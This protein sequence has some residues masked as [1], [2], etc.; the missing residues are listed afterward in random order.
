MSSEDLKRKL[1][2][3]PNEAGSYQMLNRDGHIIYVGKAKNIKKRVNS[4]FTHAIS[5]KTK[6]L[7]N[8]IYD[9]K[10]IVT[11]TELEALILEINL[12]KKYNPKYNI[13]LKDDKSYPYIELDKT[14]GP[15]LRVVRN[16]KRKKN[17]TLFGPFP[18]V[19]A[20][21]KTVAMLNRI[22]PLRKCDPLK[23][24]LCLYYH[25]GECL[26]YCAS[27]IPEE[28]TDKMIKE[29]TSF[30]N[31]NSDKIV[32]KIKEEM[33]EASSKLN[34]EKAK[35]LKE[36][37][38]SVEIT[39][40]KQKIELPDNYNFDLINF[41]RNN[42]YIS[43][44]IFYIREGKLFTVHSD[45]VASFDE[46]SE[47]LTEYIIKHY[48]KK[49]LLPKELVVPSNIDNNLLED[50]LK[51]KVSS[52]VKGRVKKLLD[53]AMD[54]AKILLEEKEELVAAK[55]EKRQQAIEELNK[56]LG[57]DIKRIEA[58][59]NSHLFGT[60]YVSASVSFD[61]FV[62]NKN[63]YRKF[64]INTDK[65]DD[66][67]A[68]KEAIY[69]RYYKVIMNEEEASDLLLIDGGELQVSAAK[70]VIDS[71]GV[72][73]EII[74]LKKDARHRSSSVINSSLEEL[75]IKKDSSLF[76]YLS[77][78]QEEVH[79]FAITYHRQIKSK[80]MLS[81][82]LDGVAGIGEV[83][84]KELQKHFPSVKK[85][86]EASIDELAKIIGPSLAE[87]L[88]KYLKELT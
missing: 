88:Y 51:T 33:Y 57:K 48:D 77:R 63:A 54:N 52:P 18:N 85:M 27:K 5:G 79:R 61:Y 3:L 15:I 72:K 25:L 14:N 23:K 87:D 8:D 59:D 34:F 11:S 4:Y 32:S 17:A 21:K 50:Y 12:I 58:F 6:M 71:L 42:N 81:S 82:L 53:L 22:Y 64:R 16:I 9:I 39:L 78:I 56:L 49:S 75:N 86:K 46:D 13:L 2:L 84:K 7:V 19:I 76:L 73:V 83:R 31:G 44:V 28:V 45:I 20:A 30:L 66:L 65:I 35:E 47:L 67:A 55:D 43:I 62:A 29:V 24:N 1:A 37:L 80:G 26:G 74:G 70:E 40:S 38:D 69:R 41:Y 36:M 10:Y 60:F 68:M